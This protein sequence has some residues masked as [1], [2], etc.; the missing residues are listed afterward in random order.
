MRAATVGLQIRRSCRATRNTDARRAPSVPA[1]R[2]RSAVF[3][4]ASSAQNSRNSATDNPLECSRD[5]I[6]ATRESRAPCAAASRT[7]AQPQQRRVIEESSCSGLHRDAQVDAI[8]HGPDMR[9]R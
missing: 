7:G 1:A 3:P 6:A 2:L 4:V 5:A 8:Q 9:A